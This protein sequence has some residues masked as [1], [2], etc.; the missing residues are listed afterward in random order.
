MSSNQKSHYI[1][2]KCPKSGIW[3]HCSLC[4]KTNSMHHVCV[5]HGWKPFAWVTLYQSFDEVK[6]DVGLVMLFVNNHLCIYNENFSILFTPIGY[7]RYLIIFHF[8]F[9]SHSGLITMHGFWYLD[10]IVLESIWFKRKMNQII[11]WTYKYFLIGLKIPTKYDY[12]LVLQLWYSKVGFSL[13]LLLNLDYWYD[14]SMHSPIYWSNIGKNVVTMIRDILLPGPTM[15]RC[16]TT[17]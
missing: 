5:V 14:I 13:I 15:I 6:T 3:W 11:I 12:R 10:K 4:C 8:C 7:A 16:T 2:Q 17:D 1:I 9:Q